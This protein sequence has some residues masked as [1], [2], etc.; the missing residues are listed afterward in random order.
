M[1][2]LRRQLAESLQRESASAGENVRLAKELQERRI[3][4]RAGASEGNFRSPQH[5]QPLADG[6]TAGARGYRGERRKGLRN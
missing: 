3:A 5:H 2:S 1:P 4:R 6:R